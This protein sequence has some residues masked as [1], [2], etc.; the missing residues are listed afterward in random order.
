MTDIVWLTYRKYD[1]ETKLYTGDYCIREGEP[2][3]ANATLVGD[4]VAEGKNY[5]NGKEWGDDPQAFERALPGRLSSL[6]VTADKFARDGMD[7]NSRASLLWYTADP[8]C[9]LWRHE[10]ITAVQGWWSKVWMHYADCKA[11][12]LSGVVAEFDPS[13]PGKCPFTIWQIE[14]E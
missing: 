6:W 4:P 2:A 5:W 14:Q 3:P 13:V 1:P 9:P 12:L 11:K 8:G 7:E 10:R